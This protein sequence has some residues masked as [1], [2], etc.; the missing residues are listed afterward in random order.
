M[1]IEAVKLIKSEMKY[2]VFQ[3]SIPVADQSM[4]EPFIFNASLK[5]EFNFN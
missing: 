2:W 1:D 5:Y 3:K 4:T